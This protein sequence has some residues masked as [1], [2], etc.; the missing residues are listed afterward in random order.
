MTIIP[1]FSTVATGRR[2]KRYRRHKLQ[3][4]KWFCASFS[5]YLLRPSSWIC[6]SSYGPNDDRNECQGSTDD[7]GDQL[8]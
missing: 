8:P 6:D 1:G 7:S 5:W 4:K 2:N 3:K